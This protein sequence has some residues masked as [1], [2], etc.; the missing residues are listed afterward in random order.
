MDRPTFSLALNS[1]LPGSIGFCAQNRPEVAAFV[2]KAQFELLT[3]PLAPDEGWWGG[4]VEMLFNIIPDANFTATVTTPNDIARLIVLDICNRARP[5]RNGF[6]EYLQFGTGHRP[7]SCGH[8]QC[9]TQQAFDR[10]PV[11]TLTPFPTSAPQFIRLFPT[12]AADV[13]KRVV[14]QGPD[15]NGITV[16]GTD[17]STG[18]SN[19]GETLLLSFPFSISVNEFQ[20]ITGFI[21]DVTKGPVQIFVVDPSTGNQTLLSSMQPNETT[22][23]YRQY[24]IAGLPQHCCN[25]PGN[26][27]QIYAQA[28]LD[29]VPVVA[30]TDYL[31]IPNV[32]ALEEQCQSIKYSRM[33]AA[34][35]PNLEAKHH[36]KAISLLNGQLDHFLG[37]TRVAVN[38]PLFG[39]NRPRPSFQ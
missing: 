20:K 33:D 32:A 18:A 5:I 31:I 26:T 2:N 29:F 25:T 12:D 7:R 14:I 19:L 11:P 35:A 15:K 8:G 9:D 6:Y 30:D 21:K 22:A 16:L 23:S 10:P 34:N 36:K 1:T 4:W 37:K 28:K 39:S 27:V 24:L 38:V 13:G 3:D 17:P